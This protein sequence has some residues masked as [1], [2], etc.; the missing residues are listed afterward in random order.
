MQLSVTAVCRQVTGE[1][2]ASPLENI[3][4]GHALYTDAPETL[5]QQGLEHRGPLD[6]VFSEILRYFFDP[7]PHICHPSDGKRSF[8]EFTAQNNQNSVP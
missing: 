3:L 5:V 4:C 8:I 1:Y 2:L 6:L 7:T